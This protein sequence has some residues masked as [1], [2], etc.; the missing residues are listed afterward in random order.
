MLLTGVFIY[1]ALKPFIP[2]THDCKIYVK[3]MHVNRKCIHV[4]KMF[5]EFTGIHTH[6]HTRA[7][8]LSKSPSNQD[9]GLQY[10]LINTANQA[11]INFCAEEVVCLSISEV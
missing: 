8:T 4:P 1:R 2:S 7:R 3:H 11:A 5:S 10:N 6:T 9:D